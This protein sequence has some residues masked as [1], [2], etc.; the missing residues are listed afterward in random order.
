MGNVIAKI[1]RLANNNNKSLLHLQSN[2][3]YINRIILNI[4]SFLK[5]KLLPIVYLTFV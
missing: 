3:K 4:F 1:Q 5:Q 2:I